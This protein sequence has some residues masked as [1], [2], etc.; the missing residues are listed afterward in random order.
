MVMLAIMKVH[1]SIREEP[2]HHNANVLN[3]AVAD[4]RQVKSATGNRGTFDRENPK[5]TEAKRLPPKLNANFSRWFGN[6]M[7]RNPNGDPLVVHHG[8]NAH[9]YVDGEIDVFQ[10]LPESGRG[11]AF[12]SS[13]KEM[14]GEYGEKVYSVYLRIE[15]P[16]IVFGDGKSW[17]SLDHTTRISG[18]VTDQLRSYHRK[19]AQDVNDLYRELGL[20]DDG[21]EH[22]EPQSQIP[23]DTSELGQ[24]RL[25]ILPDINDGSWVDTDTIVKQARR[26]G[27]DGVIFKE[28]NDSPTQDKH[29]YKNALTDVYAVFHPNQIKSIFNN[30]EWNRS[31][32]DINS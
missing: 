8:S 22:T 20:T 13:S 32:A 27:Y 4:G 21:G 1:L 9:A 30:G 23:D 26:M 2:G 14:A 12:F 19:E 18:R 15:N 5:L 3:F 10:T 29:L 25:N 16:L 17:G 7:V 28:I 24:F 31:E 11:A 6:S